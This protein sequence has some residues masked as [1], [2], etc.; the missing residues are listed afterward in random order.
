MFYLTVTDLVPEAEE[1]QYQQS[2]ALSIAGG[3]IIIF[4]LSRFF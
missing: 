4:I 1:H 2:S 3:F